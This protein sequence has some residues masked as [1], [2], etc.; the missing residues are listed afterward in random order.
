MGEIEMPEGLD[1]ETQAGEGDVAP[2]SPNA[3]AQTGE[4]DEGEGAGKGEGSEKKGAWTKEQAEITRLQ[5]ERAELQTK[6]AQAERA[7]LVASARLELQNR[8]SPAAAPAARAARTPEEQLATDAINK[9]VR[10]ELDMDRPALK[11]TLNSLKGG[12]GNAAVSAMDASMRADPD[13]YP[14]YAEVREV[15]MQYAREQGGSL[16][17]EG[18]EYAYSRLE[19]PLETRDRK[20]RRAAT[21]KAKTGR[22]ESLNAAPLPGAGGAGGGNA[23]ITVADLK[24][25]SKVSD[26]QL[27]AMIEDCPE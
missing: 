20:A 23:E 4:G 10:D 27:A 7:A 9:I 14:H 25:P 6:V 18:F 11:A 24:D 22:R 2:G 1:E 12:I 13:A 16:T 26:D 15:L 5:Q 17:P 8:Q 3:P 21:A 19:R